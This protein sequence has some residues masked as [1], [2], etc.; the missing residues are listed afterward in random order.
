MCVWAQAHY[1]FCWSG[2]A[3]ICTCCAL[4]SGP[5]ALPRKLVTPQPL[6]LRYYQAQFLR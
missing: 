4:S 6:L 5:T 1:V 2:L 3:I